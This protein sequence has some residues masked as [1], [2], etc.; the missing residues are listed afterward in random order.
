MT[1]PTFKVVFDNLTK[2][3]AASL[4]AFT[5]EL[6][7]ER[8]VMLQNE[9]VQ[10]SRILDTVEETMKGLEDCGASKRPQE[11]VNPDKVLLRGVVLRS[12]QK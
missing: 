11:Q 1:E 4:L 9:I 3:E 5:K 10:P 8:L 7:H 6:G 2:G 12:K